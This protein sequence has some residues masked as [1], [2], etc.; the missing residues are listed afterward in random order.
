MVSVGVEDPLPSARIYNIY[1]VRNNDEIK[2]SFNRVPLRLLPKYDE[3]KWRI[4]KWENYYWE[5]ASKHITTAWVWLTRI[6]STVYLILVMR[7][8][9]STKWFFIY[10]LF[11]AALT[12]ELFDSRANFS[13][14]SRALV[15]SDLF[16]F[17][18]IF[19]V[20]HSRCSHVKL[21]KNWIRTESTQH[22][23]WVFSPVLPLHS[24]DRYSG[25]C[26][27]FKWHFNTGSSY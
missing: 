22:L 6:F 17:A 14:L 21:T 27:L 5:A 20:R 18:V 1:Y 10:L 11:R 19:W 7:Q 4:F 13:I 26:L 3:Y 15:R 23:I 25:S 8:W 2:T 12:I 9:I 16:S 24:H